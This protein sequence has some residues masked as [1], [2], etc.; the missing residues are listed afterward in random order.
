M[1]NYMLQSKNVT[2]TEEMLS[3]EVVEYFRDKSVLITGGTG[4]FGN[5]ILGYLLACRAER[6]IVFSRDEAKQYAMQ[7]EYGDQP[8][9]RFV[10]GDV[11]DRVRVN[12]AMRGIDIVFNAAALKQVPNCESHPI[13][14]VMTNVI[15]AE[16]ICRSALQNGVEAVLA[17]STDKAAKPINVMGMTKAIQ[18]RILLSH[19]GEGPTRFVVVRYGNVLGSRGSVVPLFR[20]RIEQ[21][22]PLYVTDRKMTR[23][24]LTLSDAVQLVFKALLARDS[25]SLYVKRAPAANIWDMAEV[26]A[27]E[28]SGRDDYPI[29]ETHIRPGEK[30]HEVLV[31]EEEMVRADDLG[32]YF[33]VR[34]Y[35][36]M[37]KTPSS[38]SM[39][40]YTSQNTTRLS[41][42]ELTQLLRKEDW[43]T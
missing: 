28:I 5:Y 19:S 2:I 1:Y 6:I 27:S 41:G 17:I 16:N 29:E 25:G 42:E 32:D 38:T 9:L 8:G 34:P 14:A 3:G 18:E 20:Q 21:G 30:I 35:G 13:E 33:V 36:S 12:E 15:G 26:M 4:S 22:L 10:I 37:P 24:I 31:S 23:F 40:E 39:R 43:V 11:R 7:M